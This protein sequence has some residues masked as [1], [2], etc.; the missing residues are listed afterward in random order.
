[1]D[2]IKI[3]GGKPLLG[4]V[5]VGGAKNAALPIL[6]STLLSDEPCQLSRV[7]QLQDVRT[8][9]KLL[10]HLGTKVSSNLD[11]NSVELHSNQ[12]SS[13]ESPYDLVRTMRAYV[14]VLGPLLARFGK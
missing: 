12:I 7:P 14:V 11:L 8:V 1:M 9:L 3:R 10:S 2:R 13:F 6:I 4:T 5:R